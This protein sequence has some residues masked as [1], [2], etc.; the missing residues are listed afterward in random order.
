MGTHSYF[1]CGFDLYKKQPNQKYQTM[2]LL[3]SVALTG[4]LFSTSDASMKSM[5]KGYNQLIKQIRQS[6]NRNVLDTSLANV[7]KYGCWC[8]FDDAVGNGKG[9]PMD[10]ID[11]ECRNLHRGYECALADYGAS[12]VPWEVVYFP[13]AGTPFVEN[14]GGVGPACVHTN[15][16]VT[17]FGE[18]AA[19]ACAIETQF[20]DDYTSI[21]QNYNPQFA[22]YSHTSTGQG[23]FNPKRNCV[24]T[25]AGTPDK[26]ARECCGTYPYRYPFKT[27][28]GTTQCC[29]G[30]VF[31]SAT[32]KCCLSGSVILAASKCT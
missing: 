3:T 17:Q 6:G 1:W 25:E 32:H 18:C 2:K 29:Q 4:Y 8:Y 19:A 28:G 16:V 12:C 9:E 27:Y 26:G 15:T 22:T 31:N 5:R 23:N 21:T 20:I 11:A 10:P 30:S 14:F 24:T 7:D 13:V